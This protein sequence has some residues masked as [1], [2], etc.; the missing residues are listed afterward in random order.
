MA[1]DKPY[2]LC[3]RC[4]EPL[5]STLDFPGAEFYCLE[6][7][8]R[9]GFLSPRPGQPTPELEARYRAL[10][11]EWDE[12]VAGRLLLHGGWLHDCEQCKPHAEPHHA[13][14]TEEEW[15]EHHKALMWLNERAVARVGT[16]TYKEEVNG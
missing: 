15:D 7:R 2:A 10:Q 4:G 1:S 11:A 8:Q 5:V 16:I 12:H 3:P 13:H 9:Y 6:C 14:A